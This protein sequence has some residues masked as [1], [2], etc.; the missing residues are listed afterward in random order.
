MDAVTFIDGALDSVG[1]LAKI[2]ILVASDRASSN[3]Y[4]D[5]GGPAILQFLSEAIQSPLEVHY[6]CI[7]DRIEQIESTILELVD[8][9]G[10]SV[11]VTTGG[12][13]PA[14]R[15]VT[16]EATERVVDRIMP[17]FGEQMR[18]ISLQYTPTAILSRQTA[19]VRGSCLIFNLPGRPKSIRETIDEIWKA[20]P[21]C[22]DLIGGPYIETNADVCDSFRPKNAM[23]S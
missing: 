6:R 2:G 7:P 19:G 9:V 17:G 14:P 10:C 20:V 11:V 16:P 22:V 13:G 1:E 5:E 12:T 4:Q 3:E 21:Y 15:D 8:A 23:R 18:A